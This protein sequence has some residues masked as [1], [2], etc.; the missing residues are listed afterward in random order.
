MKAKQKIR[1]RYYATLVLIAF[2]MNA[3]LPSISTAKS[4]SE[5]ISSM[6]MVL[7]C[8]ADGMKWISLDD[9]Q[10]GKENPEIQHSLKFPAITS[11]TQLLKDFANLEITEIN[12]ATFAYTALVQVK[13]EKSFQSPK[14]ISGINSRAP[15]ALS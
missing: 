5:Q 12:F 9:L 1:N 10:S 11:A 8:A 3:L 14:L 15:P 7:I 2:A 4:A 13:T 6:N